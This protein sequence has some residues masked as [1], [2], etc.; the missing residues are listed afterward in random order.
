VNILVTGGAG[1]IGSHVVDAYRAAGHRVAVLDWKASAKKANISRGITVYE[2]DLAKADLKTIFER[3]RFDIVNHHAAQASVPVSVKDPIEDARINVMGLL[4][5]MEAARQTGVKKVIFAQSGGTVYGPTDRLPAEESLPFD[6]ASPYGVTKVASELYL[7]VYRREHGI[8]FTA[9]RYAN[10]YGPRQDAHGESGVVSIF[11]ER[12]LNREPPVIHGDG[13]YL[14]D[15]VY[16]GDVARAN[17][18]AL[19]GG[20]DEGINIGTGKR[21]S[22]NTVFRTLAKLTSFTGPETHG[23]PRAGDLR[24]S[25]LAIGKARLVLGWTPDVDIESGLAQTVQW[26]R[27]RI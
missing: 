4:N 24:D 3:E 22:T 8:R 19:D 21:T 2:E 18:L 9:L 27:G 7:R 26:F 1:F 20:D 14:R 23:P 11:I 16:V 12:M 10:V 13:E 15:Y 6:A 5:L 25:C 17:L